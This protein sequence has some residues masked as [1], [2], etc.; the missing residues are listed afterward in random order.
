MT[1]PDNSKK[2]RDEEP[3]NV[4]Q[5]FAYHPSIRVINDITNS[6]PLS[7]DV[8]LHPAFTHSCA[9][10]QANRVGKVAGCEGRRYSSVVNSV[11]TSGRSIGHST[12]T[13]NHKQKTVNTK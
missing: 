11:L 5:L 1:T 6:A 12:Q 10:H 8:H 2:R 4:S 13:G 7:M 3:T 9:I